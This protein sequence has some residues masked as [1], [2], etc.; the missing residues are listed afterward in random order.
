MVDC[1][2]AV[3]FVFDKAKTIIRKDKCGKYSQYYCQFCAWRPPSESNPIIG[4]ISPCGRCTSNSQYKICIFK[5]TKA[6]FISSSLG[7][8]T[9]LDDAWN[10]FVN[11]I[12]YQ[13]GG[14]FVISVTDSKS[15]SNSFY[16]NM[17]KAK[18]CN[19]CDSV[20]VYFK[21]NIITLPTYC[22]E[23]AM[24]QPVPPDV[25]ICPPSPYVSSCANSLSNITFDLETRDYY[26]VR[27]FNSPSYVFNA[28]LEPCANFIL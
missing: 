20:L 12:L 11:S 28:S 3:G 8:S 6:H 7:I 15:C 5:L 18:K 26:N 23:V 17:I 24:S 10:V 22:Q 1:L 4:S 25:N 27:F 2:S 16:A 19:C 14:N 9:G 21:Y 13:R